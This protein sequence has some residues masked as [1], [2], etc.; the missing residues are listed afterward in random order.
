M[1]VM[2]IKLQYSI[3][4]S[5]FIIL[6]CLMP[7]NFIRQ[8]ESATTQ[9]VSVIPRWEPLFHKIVIECTHLLPVSK[10]TLL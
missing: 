8:V 1:A 5:Y 9:W 3:S 10:Q 2:L 7:D 6:L 4:A